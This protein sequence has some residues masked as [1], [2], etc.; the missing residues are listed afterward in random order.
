MLIIAGVPT[1]FN[2]FPS[3]HHPTISMWKLL[4]A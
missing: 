2:T 4:D 3:V 1:Y